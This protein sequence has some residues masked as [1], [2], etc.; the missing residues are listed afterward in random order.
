MLRSVLT[1]TL[2]DARRGFVW[3]SLGLAALVLISV[4]FWP[5][6]RDNEGFRRFERDAPEALKAF[7]GGHLDFTT[8]VGYLDARLF[9]LVVPLLFL[10]YAIGW[11]ARAIA[12]EEEAGTLEL[13]LAHPISRTRLAL[14]KLGALTFQ[15]ATFGVVL[16]VVVV[17]SAR[18]VS[19]DISSARIAQAVIAIYLLAL[20]HGALALAIGAA[21]GRRTTALGGAAAVAVAGYFL[22]GLGQVVDALEPWRVLSPF[23]WAGEPLRNGLDAGAI[24]LAVAIVAA[25]CAAVP[26]FNRRDIAV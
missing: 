26:L 10:V 22:N 11:G 4:A 5:S 19:L 21:T 7:T 1:K 23:D 2:R 6:V 13:L 16:L 12:G 24:A 9:A 20:A 15:L 25:A 3:W 17:V 14:E 18:A 8:P